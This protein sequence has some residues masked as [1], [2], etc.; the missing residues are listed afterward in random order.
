MS[1]IIKEKLEYKDFMEANFPK[2]LKPFY[3]KRIFI[4]N[5]AFA[6]LYIAAS[7]Y[8]FYESY[9]KGFTLELQHYGFAFFALLFIALP[10]YLHRREKK[11]YTKLVD[12][13]NDLQTTYTINDNEIKV[14]NKKANLVYK[15]KNVNNFIVLDKWLVFEMK[16]EER[17]AIYKPN[18][19]PEDMT[20]VLKI[21]TS[22]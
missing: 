3:T 19:Q 6:S 22:N 1:I 14:D 12:D 18:I 17:L 20:K 13:I 2:V 15:N 11:V 16:N 10:F 8:I 5:M 4:M 21:Y 9:K 7:V